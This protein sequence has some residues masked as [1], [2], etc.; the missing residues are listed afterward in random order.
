[1]NGIPQQR[2]DQIQ[3][4]L[5]GVDHRPWRLSPEEALDDEDRRTVMKGSKRAAK[6]AERKGFIAAA[7]RGE[8]YDDGKEGPTTDTVD[9]D[10]V[11]SHL[12]LFK[13]TQEA[14]DDMLD[15]VAHAPED[16]DDLLKEVFCL[17]ELTSKLK[18]ERDSAVKEMLASRIEACEAE[19]KIASMRRAW[20]ELCKEMGTKA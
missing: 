3:L 5:I 13:R 11:L 15:F 2:L 6:K 18:V 9:L 1:M 20:R 17:R 4:R 12:V 14:T 19:K 7:N 8:V 16:V 10:A